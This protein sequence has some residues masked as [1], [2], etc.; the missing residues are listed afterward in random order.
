M[1]NDII[2]YALQM[3]R[4]GQTFYEN[5]AAET[6]DTDLKQILLY[7]AEE[8][9]RHYRFFQRLQEGN[10]AAAEAALAG[11]AL[12][13]GETK[14][15]FRQMVDAKTKPNVG[16]GARSVWQDALKIEE[17]VEKLYRD[18]AAAESDPGRQALLH[19]IADEEKNHVYLIDNMLSF[20]ADP[21]GFA[22]SA[23]YK[24]YLSWEGR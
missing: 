12:S 7:L 2:A 20:L 8:E 21:S 24:N 4:D 5:S 23:N 6:A 18:H 16:H 14:S 19:R 17:R 1:L 11:G 22:D 9:Q 10:V 15:L 13:L 3:E